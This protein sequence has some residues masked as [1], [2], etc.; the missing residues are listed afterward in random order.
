VAIVKRKKET[1][2]EL[3]PRVRRVVAL[4]MRWVLGTHLGAVSVEHLEAYLD[5][6]TLRFNRRTSRSR[7]KLFFRLLQQAVAVNPAP[8]KSLVKCYADLPPLDTRYRGCGSQI[9][10]HFGKNLQHSATLPPVAGEL[11]F[12]QTQ[13][14]LHSVATRADCAGGSY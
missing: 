8:Y 7:G 13:T 9:N 14:L 11:L 10:T 2:S 3:M 4:L 12:L 5:E 6:F 1:A